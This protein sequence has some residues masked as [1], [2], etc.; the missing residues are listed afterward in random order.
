[1][2][3]NPEKLCV[4]CLQKVASVLK[5][6]EFRWKKQ[7]EDCIEEIYRTDKTHST[8][9]EQRKRKY[10]RTDDDNNIDQLIDFNAYEVSKFLDI[11]FNRLLEN[12]LEKTSIE[13]SI[14]IS[15][16]ISSWILST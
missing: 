11:H 4:I 9:T 7:V 13:P 14:N 2:V 16:T 1:M 8:S 5:Y 15:P 10:P 12:F 6:E 3:D